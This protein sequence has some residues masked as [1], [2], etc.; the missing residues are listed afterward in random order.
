LWFQAHVKA[1]LS[2]LEKAPEKAQISVRCTMKILPDFTPMKLILFD[3]DGT[4]IDSQRMICAAMHQ[5]YQDHGLVCPPASE[6]RAIIGL[7]L[8]HAFQKL[9]GGT[10]HPLESLATR[11]KQAFFTLREAG[12]ELPAL[13]PGAGEAIAGLA[14]RPDVMLGLATGKSRRGAAAMIEQ[15]GFHGVFTTIQTADTAPSKPHP[16][17]VLEAMR[18]TGV[19]AE[20][21]V[22]VGDTAFDMAMARAAGAAA[23]GV[24]WGYHPVAD[25]HAA[26]AHVVVDSFDA[27]LLALDD[28]WPTPARR[29]VT[30]DA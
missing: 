22:V 6:V 11:Y 17:M 1:G 14:A 19:G 29:G 20:H 23:I 9:S 8:D 7:S 30:A 3:V 27:L 28:L 5:A 2:V 15:H 4:L 13:Y 18:E 24:S 26:G 12:H 25:L 10:D 21:T 16:G